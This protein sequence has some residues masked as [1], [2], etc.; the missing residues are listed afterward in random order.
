MFLR[1][2]PNVPCN[3]CPTD[4]NA[5]D[6]GISFSW[7]ITCKDSCCQMADS[8][9]SENTNSFEIFRYNLYCGN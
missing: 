1:S 4:K 8:A 5:N 3:Q 9:I 6:S 2:S 7:G